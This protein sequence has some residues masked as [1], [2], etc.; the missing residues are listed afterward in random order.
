VIYRTETQLQHST[1]SDKRPT[2]FTAVIHA[3]SDQPGVHSRP[4][5][6]DH[7]GVVKNGKL[8]SMQQ[9]PRTVHSETREPRYT[10]DICSS[11][12]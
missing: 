3:R 7:H 6:D 11:V 5:V 12:M 4:L 8:E 9:V 10:D 1:V 2:E